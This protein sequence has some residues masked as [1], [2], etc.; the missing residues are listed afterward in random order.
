MVI[1]PTS[2]KKTG[3]AMVLVSDSVVLG[4][5]AL[6]E[7]KGETGLTLAWRKFLNS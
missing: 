7:T 1:S 4:V 5:V 2:D 6:M 3:A